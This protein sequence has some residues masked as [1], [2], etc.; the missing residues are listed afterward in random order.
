MISERT[1]DDDASPGQE[2]GSPFREVMQTLERPDTADFTSP[3]KSAGYIQN[4]G[5]FF[6]RESVSA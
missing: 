4:K 2:G 3:P 5:Y 1:P 6:L